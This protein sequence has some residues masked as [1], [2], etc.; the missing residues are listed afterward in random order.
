MFNDYEEYM[1]SVLGYK[2]ADTYT[3]SDNYYYDVGRMNANMQDTSRL[4]PEIYGI[5]YPMVQKVCSRRNFGNLTEEMLN[6]MV[7]EIYNVIEPEEE[8][9]ERNIQKSVDTKNMRQKEQVKEPRR[10]RPNNYL[11]RDLI[12]IL[13]LREILSGG[14]PVFIPGMPGPGRTSECQVDQVDHQCH[15][16]QDQEDPEEWDHAHL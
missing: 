11:L 12:R 7:N 4:Y 13:I 10:A 15:L 14:G 5:I 6:E 9:E 1:R 3:Q 8:L 2:T 16:H